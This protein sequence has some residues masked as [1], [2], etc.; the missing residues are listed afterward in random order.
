M[1]APPSMEQRMATDREKATKA[2]RPAGEQ[3]DEEA[4]AYLAKRHRV[5][6]A[7]VRGIIR[8]IGTSERAAVEREIRKGN[9][10]R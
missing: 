9:S 4:V 6:A 2:T 5:S 3:I 10:R 7:I 1:T 8:A